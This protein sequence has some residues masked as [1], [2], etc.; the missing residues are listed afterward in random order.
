M[1]PDS[2]KFAV[3]L[4]TSEILDTLVVDS[5]RPVKISEKTEFASI[6]GI[7]IVLVELTSIVCSES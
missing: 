6:F 3:K 1:G 7:G 2:S 4:A 5:L